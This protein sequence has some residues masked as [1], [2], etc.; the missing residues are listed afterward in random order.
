MH[1][2]VGE[3][4]GQQQG[5]ILLFGEGEGEHAL[6]CHC[7]NRCADRF[8]DLKTCLQTLTADREQTS[9]VRH[10]ETII[11]MCSFSSAPSSDHVADGFATRAL[12]K[13]ISLSR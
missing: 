1:N 10:I 5:Q 6:G 8:E 13:A 12:V 2:V 3:L 11:F 9:N 7:V 4:A